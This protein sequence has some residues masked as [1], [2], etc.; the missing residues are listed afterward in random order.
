MNILQTNIVIVYG[1]ISFLIFLEGLF[2]SVKKRNTYKKTAYL[3]W[4]GIFVWGDAVIFG[5]F[6]FFASLI[7]YLLKDWILFLL[8]ISVFWIIRSFG[9]TIYWINQ[10]F[11]SINRNPPEK[12]FGY[13]LFKN[14]SIWFNYQIFWQCISVISIITSLYLIQIRFFK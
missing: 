8:I 11:S 3:F 9:E 4:L 12:M 6:W 14:S 10:Q 1:L 13:Q 7:S 5:L 2:E